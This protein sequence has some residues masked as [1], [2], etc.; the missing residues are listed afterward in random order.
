LVEALPKGELAVVDRQRGQPKAR[1]VRATFLRTLLLERVSDIDPRGLRLANALIIGRLD[2]SYVKL[3][4]SLRFFRCAWLEPVNFRYSRLS[5]LWMN[6]CR[7]RRGLWAGGM[8]VDGDCSLKEAR[9]WHEARFLNADIEGDLMCGSAHFLNVGGK[10]FSADRMKVAGGMFLHDVTADGE[11]RLMGVEIRGNLECDSS[12]LCNT[13]GNAL[14]AERMKVTGAVFLR[15]NLLIQGKVNLGGTEIN[16]LDFRPTGESSIKVMQLGGARLNMWR[17][18]A[19]GLAVVNRL[20]LDGCI[21]EKLLSQNNDDGHFDFRKRLPRGMGFKPQPYTQLAKVLKADGHE[22]TA[23]E[24]LIER[25]EALRETTPGL[26]LRWVWLTFQKYAAGYGYR[27]RWTLQ[28][29]VAFWLV[30]TLF[31]GLAGMSGQAKPLADRLMVP[32]RLGTFLPKGA[33]GQAQANAV[34]I[35]AQYPRFEPFVYSLDA[36]VPFLDLQ[37]EDYWLPNANGGGVVFSLPRLGSYTSGTLL[38]WYLWFH[39]AVGW[40]FGTMFVASI[41]GLIKKE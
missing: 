23:R 1:T 40:L 35:P 9:V 41:T 17:Y 8:R 34:E 20:S 39:I 5:G 11:I 24:V 26:G 14:N 31:F 33:N 21:Y 15:N 27:P 30:G 19:K 4:R 13:G 10:A 32:A 3:G 12:R 29:L 16:Q 22:D 6:H 25:Q 36:L 38:R 37:Q 28:W 18:S 7:L 2:L